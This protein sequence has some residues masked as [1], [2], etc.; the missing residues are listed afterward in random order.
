MN[1]EQTEI[2]IESQLVPAQILKSSLEKLDDW[3]RHKISLSLRCTDS[4][5]RGI[6]STVLVAL[7]GIAGTAAGSLISG[8]LQVLKEKHSAKIILQTRSGQ[9]LEMPA[10]L[11]LEEID[12]LIQKLHSLEGSRIYIEGKAEGH[13]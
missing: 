7:V 11:S 4:A 2:I 3:S 1:A 8:I 9:R 10:T 6:D 5:V 13:N 12:G